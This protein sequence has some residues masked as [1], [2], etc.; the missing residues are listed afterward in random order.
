M[1]NNI[2]WTNPK[3][4][5]SKYFIVKEALYL[6]SWQALH[7]PSKVE[8]ENIL[9][10]AEKMDLVREFIKST[11]SVHCWIRPVLNNPASPY[12]GQDYNAHVKG[13]PG[14]SHKTGLA[15][16]WSCIGSNCD[17]LRKFLIGKLAE[18]D[19]RMED[20]PKSTWIHLAADYKTGNYFFKP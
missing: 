19:L 15:V 11:I 10:L 18:W 2:D 6:P 13:A 7:I 16:D 14:S 1:T 12:H 5:I 4:K 3:A 9:K 20:L 8:Q 17:D